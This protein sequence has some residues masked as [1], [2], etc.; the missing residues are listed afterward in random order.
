MRHSVGLGVGRGTEEL[1]KREEGGPAEFLM[2]ME[3]WGV[4][5]EV[6]LDWLLGDA[7][8]SGKG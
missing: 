5:A 7:R 2:S 4:S 3:G 8:G 6:G 1:M